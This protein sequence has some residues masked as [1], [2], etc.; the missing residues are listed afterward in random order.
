MN[1]WWSILPPV[2]A[3]GLALWT[4]QIVVSLLVG[5]F[6]GWL[7]VAAGNPFEGVLSTA[8]SLVDVFSDRGSAAVLVFTLLVGSLLMLIQRSG[9]SRVSSP[10]SAAGTGR[11]P[12]AAP[13]S[14]PG[15]WDLAS[16]SSRTSPR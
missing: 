13:S 7:I 10:G 6:I 12:G 14:W 15:A 9:G 1:G 2:V 5:I 8:D 11:P 3:I 16:S 4:R